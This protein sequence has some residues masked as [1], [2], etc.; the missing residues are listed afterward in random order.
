MAAGWRSGIKRSLNQNQKKKKKLRQECDAA[1]R[2]EVM[3]ERKEEN[4]QSPVLGG[5]GPPVH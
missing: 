1:E 3:M 2:G 4:V 5:G